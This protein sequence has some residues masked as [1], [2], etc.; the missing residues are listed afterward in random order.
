MDITVEPNV[1]ISREIIWKE[2][3][4]S[5]EGK[6]KLLTPVKPTL[7]SVNYS[8]AGGLSVHIKLPLSLQA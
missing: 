7:D 1:A 2:A 6:G 5:A 3:G 4:P 8:V